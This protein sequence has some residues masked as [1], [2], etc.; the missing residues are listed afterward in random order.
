V[1]RLFPTSLAKLVKDKLSK[2]DVLVFGYD[3]HA[4]P[5]SDTE[6]EGIYLDR[7]LFRKRLSIF[8]DCQYIFLGGSDADWL[9]PLGRIDI[10]I[11]MAQIVRQE[12]F[13]PL[14]L[15]QYATLVVPEA[16]KAGVDVD[17][18]AVPLN[19]EWS[20]FDRDECVDIISSL[21]KPVIAFMPLASGKLRENV[22]GALEWLY[23]DAGVESILYGTATLGHAAETTRMAHEIRDSVDVVRSGHATN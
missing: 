2:E 1:S 16:E 20:W 23:H 15:C 10:L 18:Y 22:P 21:D 17:G 7:G 11:E 14:L 5:L 4:K 12:G 6:I 13:I 3:R 9:V 8:G 19:Q